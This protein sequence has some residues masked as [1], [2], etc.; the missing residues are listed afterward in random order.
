VSA[1]SQP[2]ALQCFDSRKAAVEGL[3]ASLAISKEPPVVDPLTATEAQGPALTKTEVRD[4]EVNQLY[5]LRSKVEELSKQNQL[6]QEKL[7]TLF[8]DRSN[9][10]AES[11]QEQVKTLEK[12]L[13][14]ALSQLQKQPN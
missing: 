11:S 12:Q 5:S 9:L 7:L 3:K 2:P 6:L 14:E 10:D 8:N 1:Y 13:E 4:R